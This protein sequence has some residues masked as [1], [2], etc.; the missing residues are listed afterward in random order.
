MPTTPPTVREASDDAFDRIESLLTAND[1]PSRDVRTGPGFFF[2]AYADTAIV[3]AGGV[4][5]YGSHGLVRSLVVAEPYRGSGYGT[6]VYAALEDHALSNG[7]DELYLLTTTASGFFAD[8]GY[9]TLDRE[10]A[11]TAIRET[12]QFTDLCPASATCMAKRLG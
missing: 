8:R 2:V 5:T 1:L 7:V 4:E 6:A 3:A 12:P 9:R 11:P 10:Q